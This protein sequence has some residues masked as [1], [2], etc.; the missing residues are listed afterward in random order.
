MKQSLEYFKERLKEQVK[1]LMRSI[2]AF[3][4][5]ALEEAKRMAVAIRVIAHDTR[6]SKSLL[7]HIGYK[8]SITFYDTASDILPGQINNIALLEMHMSPNDIPETNPFKPR[9]DRQPTVPRPEMVSFDQWWQ[10][11]VIYDD[12]GNVITRRELILTMANQ[13]GGAHVDSEINEAYAVLSEGKAIGWQLTIHG[14]N[15]PLRTIGLVTT[16]QIAHETLVTLARHIPKSFPTQENLD[17][18]ANKSVFTQI[19]DDAVAFWDIGI[20]T[21]IID[22]Q[23]NGKCFCGSNKKNK[24]CHFGPLAHNRKEQRKQPWISQ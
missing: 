19:A 8:D 14:K 4:T 10:R 15:Y 23:R 1:F 12:F 22:I 9:L 21:S 24:H 3:D 7:K 18:Y 20:F 16:R 17:I 2:D 6:N 13:D 5:G 11:N